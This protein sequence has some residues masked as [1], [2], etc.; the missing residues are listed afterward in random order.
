MYIPIIISHSI[1][2]AIYNP[3]WPLK[4]NSRKEKQIKGSSSLCLGWIPEP[5]GDIQ[6]ESYWSQMEA[7]VSA[8]AYND[9]HW[10]GRPYHCD[11]NKNTQ[12]NERKPVSSNRVISCVEEPGGWTGSPLQTVWRRQSWECGNNWKEQLECARRKLQTGNAN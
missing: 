1:K 7:W 8:L 4:N 6:R 5:T 12:I 11:E 2:N 3:P 10:P 9:Q